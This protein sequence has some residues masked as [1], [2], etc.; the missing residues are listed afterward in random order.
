VVEAGDEP[1]EISH[2]NDLA[3]LFPGYY[4]PTKAERQDAYRLGLVSLD[5]NALL[6]LY[7]F[8]ERA[9]NEFFEVLEKLHPRLFITHQAALEFYR[10]R[11]SVVEARLR[12]AEEK[13]NEIRQP[14]QGVVDKIQEFANRYQID[15]KER[16]RLV[17]MIND[18]SAALT[19]SITV[20]GA[21]DLTR[22]QVR[23]ATD[24][25]LQRLNVLLAGRVGDALSE[26]E[27]KLAMGEAARRREGRIPPGYAE[28]K[29]SPERQA[30]D[31]LIWRQLINEARLHERPVLLVTN[32]RKED[33][34]LK[35]S[36]NEILG[37]RPELVLEMRQ[38]AKI[39]LHMVTVVG[40]LTE[41]PEYLGTAVSAS[42]IQEAESL[43]QRRDVSVR[44]TDRSYR[45]YENLSE[46]DQSTLLGM[47]DRLSDMLKEG[48]T[49]RR[50]PRIS[51]KSKRSN[52]YLLRWSTDGRAMI[53]IEYPSDSNS[54]PII[55]SVFEINRK[56]SVDLESVQVDDL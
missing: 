25:V 4:P 6:D 34:V 51:L 16:Q 11:L 1:I 46:G 38:E 13:C 45:E 27:Y 14:L 9:R 54:D 21:Y 12:A 2:G 37:P 40:L 19:D 47:L 29:D 31:Y 17:G 15:P 43:P 33:W 56:K 49:L 44:F 28:K 32:E 7:R 5:T 55:V 36:S 26:A 8:T 10:D 52:I 48:R 39:A 42:T 50:W 35:G 24:P 3:D 41:A 53:Q 20:A 23:N 22:D 18:L 30:G